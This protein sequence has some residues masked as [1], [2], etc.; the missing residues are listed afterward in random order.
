VCCIIVVSH[1]ALVTYRDTDV[2]FPLYQNCIFVANDVTDL[3][4]NF[5]QK[6]KAGSTYRRD[7]GI[8]DPRVFHVFM[9]PTTDSENQ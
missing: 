1:V 3:S 9:L 5:V 2:V 7:S 6:K 4:L 8:S